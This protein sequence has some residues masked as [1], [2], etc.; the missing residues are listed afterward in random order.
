MN[1]GLELEYWLIDNEGRLASTTDL[2]NAYDGDEVTHE[3]IDSLLEIQTPPVETPQALRE[4]LSTL[5]PRVLEVVNE[6]DQHLVPLGTPI[7]EPDLPIITERGRLLERLYGET[8]RY[9]K[10]CAGTHVHFDKHTI[11]SQLNLLTALDPALALVNSSPY[12]DGERIA[13]SARASV[14]RLATHS[15][16]SR[17]RDLWAYVDTVEEWNARLRTEYDVLRAFATDRGISDEEFTTHFQPETAVM[18]PVRLREHS[19]TVEWRAPDTALPSQVLQL[20]TDITAILRQ[21]TEKPVIVGE[22]GVWDDR[23]AIPRFADLRR[24]STAAIADGLGSEAVRSYLTTMGIDV[25][26]YQPLSDEFHGENTV[27]AD[28]A[29]SIRLAYAERLEAD[30]NRL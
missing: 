5:L 10:N 23:I 28:R 30:I 3:F 15:Q 9:A 17:Y 26:A 14:Y 27:S 13:S 8:L 4:V 1:I 16:F 24:L 25:S 6:Q 7:T 2:L 21:T 19:P 11:S 22:P 20:I 18:T 29:R 12:Y